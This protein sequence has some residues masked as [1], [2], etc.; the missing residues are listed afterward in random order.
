M[1]CFITPFAY[2]CNAK[3]SNYGTDVETDNED[4]NSIS[5]MGGVGGRSS[6]LQKQGEVTNAAMPEEISRAMGEVQQVRKAIDRNNAIKRSIAKRLRNNQKKSE[7]FRE[8]LTHKI[9]SSE[10]RELME[11]EYRIGKL[12]LDNMELEQSRIVHDTIVRGKDLTIQKLQ[13]QLAQRDAVIVHQQ[14]VLQANHIKDE[15]LDKHIQDLES[16]KEHSC[17][18]EGFDTLRS[19]QFRLLNCASDSDL[20]SIATTTSRGS[21]KGS[22]IL[23]HS[24]SNLHDDIDVS[25]RVDSRI[26]ICST[27]VPSAPPSPSSGRGSS[28]GFGVVSPIPYAQTGME[29]ESAV[30]DST[31]ELPRKQQIALV[32]KPKRPAHEFFRILLLSRNFIN[33]SLRC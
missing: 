13:L 7:S 5:D 30:L 24:A 4:G 26:S 25:N 23:N 15:C 2:V 31:R 16:A 22:P 10:F 32:S 21:V 12:E 27:V 8:E 11:L 6:Q 3:D 14:Q 18:T 29:D 9:T 33:Q 20:A 28:L 19:G 1:C 17:M